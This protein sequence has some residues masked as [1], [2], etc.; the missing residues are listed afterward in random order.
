MH[1]EVELEPV[2]D[3]ADSDGDDRVRLEW[4]ARGCVQERL[5]PASRQDQVELIKELLAVQFAGLPQPAVAVVLL[6]QAS[7]AGPL[8]LREPVPQDA[9]G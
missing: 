1:L 3:T 9:N 7:P 5:A 6:G 2:V 4:P 8:L